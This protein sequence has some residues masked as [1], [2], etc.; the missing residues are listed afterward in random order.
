MSTK[1]ANF[2]ELKAP[3]PAKEVRWRI[4]SAGKNGNKIW[5]LVIPYIDARDCMDRLDSVVGSE[6]WQDAYREAGTALFCKLSI[7]INGVWVSKE[8]AS[9]QTEVEAIK[10][11]VSGSFKRACAKWGLGRYLY[12]LDADFGKIVDKGTPGANRAYSEKLGEFFWLPWDLPAWALP[13]GSTPQAPGAITHSETPPL[14]D[15]GAFVPDFGPFRNIRLD[16][17]TDIYALNDW[18]KRIKND[19]HP[20][21][22]QM[23]TIAATE[24]YL[25]TRMPASAVERI[26]K[27]SR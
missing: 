3:F 15:P 7:L 23:K 11:A 18:C 10:G 5:A 14:S 12:D 22:M 8:D 26:G 16:A 9:G 21:A 17:V 1:P 20:N 2:E 25:V 24:A 4:Q 6:N 19:K 27:G 13:P